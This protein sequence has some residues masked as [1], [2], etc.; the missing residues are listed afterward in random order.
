[1]TDQVAGNPAL[2][3]DPFLRRA[4]WLAMRFLCILQVRMCYRYQ[5]WGE[6][7]IPR[8]GPMLLVSN[9]QSFLDPVLVGVGTRR[10]FYSMARSTLFS[11]PFFGW[12]ISSVNAIPVERN[13]SDMT[14]IRRCIDVMK[15][16]RALLVF[17]E[18]TRSADGIVKPFASGTMLL[19]KRAKPTVVPVAIEGAFDIWPRN[20]KFPKLTGRVGVKYG[21]PQSADSLIAM[22][23][24]AALE[25]LRNQV[26]SMQLDIRKTLR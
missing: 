8:Q 16:G 4:W 6:D 7:N 2:N 15:Q 18:G 22:G 19:I 5:T 11:N 12:L 3:P 13:T 24:E 26:E 10:M 21:P 20:R 9:H 14:A 1:M 25:H 17:P 23:A